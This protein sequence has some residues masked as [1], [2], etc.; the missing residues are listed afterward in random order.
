MK[1]DGARS[2][3]TCQLDWKDSTHLPKPEGLKKTVLQDLQ[4]LYF[5][6]LTVP[7]FKGLSDKMGSFQHGHT[8]KENLLCL[9]QIIEQV[10]LYTILHIILT[11]PSPLVAESA[12]HG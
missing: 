12:I 10:F 3:G 7:I 8:C 6:I 5:F 2:I 1:G 4:M 11:S 9:L